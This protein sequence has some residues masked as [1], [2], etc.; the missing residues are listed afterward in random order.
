MKNPPTLKISDKFSNIYV[1]DKESYDVAKLDGELTTGILNLK[2]AFI[3]KPYS[4]TQSNDEASE[5]AVYTIKFFPTNSIPST[6]SIQLTW[7]AH[8]RVTE[9]A[10]CAV[11]TSA[12]FLDNCLIEPTENA[13]DGD[14]GGTITITGVFVDQEH[15]SDQITISLAVYNPVN[16]RPQELGFGIRTYADEDSAYMI[17]YLTDADYEGLLIPH[18]ECTHPCA[19]CTATDPKLCDSCWQSDPESPPFLMRYETTDASGTTTQTGECREACDMG[20]TT[21]GDPQN[22]CVECDASCKTCH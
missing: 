10:S 15:F 7:P 11:G 13:A 14:A 12:A 5:L 8:V 17:D 20:Y 16:N 22:V 19:T 9:E 1:T 6:G 21:D 4:L 3:Q 2:A 18:L